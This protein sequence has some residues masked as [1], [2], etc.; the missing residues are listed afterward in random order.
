LHESYQSADVFVLTSESEGMP[1]V[2]LEAM[3]CGLPIVTTNVP[4]NQEIVRDGENGFLINVGDTEALAKSL[5]RLIEG[6][7]LRQRMGERS[8]QLMQPYEWREIM[9]QYAGIMQEIVHPN[10]SAQRSQTERGSHS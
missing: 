8:R 1:A 7:E 3:S 10:S 9:R 5:A 2:T 4:G 6:R